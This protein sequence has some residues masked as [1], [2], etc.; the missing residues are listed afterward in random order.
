MHAAV[1]TAGPTVTRDPNLPAAWPL[2]QYLQHMGALPTAPSASRAM[3][4]AALTMWQL[5]TDLIDTAELI[6]SELVTNAVRHSHV[7]GDDGRLRPRYVY[8]RLPIVQV[9]LG[10]DRQGSLMVVVF[11]QAP[12]IPALHVADDD[13]ESGRGLAMV[14]ALCAWWDWRKVEAGKIVR[15]MITA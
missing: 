8:G 1:S 13:D 15:A 5:P 12:G 2:Q 11:D 9:A 10:S 14:A 4:R 3:V 6:T 7:A